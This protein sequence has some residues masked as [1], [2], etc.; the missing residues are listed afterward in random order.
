MELEAEAWERGCRR[1]HLETFGYQ[2]RAV[3]ERHGYMVFARLP[4]YPP[5]HERIYLHK[6][7]SWSD[8]E[9][10]RRQKFSRH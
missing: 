3:Y 4:D 5:G 2:A 8:G 9:R 10:R 1:A 6:Q 7:M